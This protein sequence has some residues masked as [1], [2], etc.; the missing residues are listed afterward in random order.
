MTGALSLGVA[1]VAAAAPAASI[2]LCVSTTAGGSVTSGGTTGECAGGSDAVALPSEASAQTKLL[3][4]LPYENFEA[5]GIDGKP[6]IQFSGANVQIISGASG[7]TLFGKENVTNGQGNLIIGYNA[8]PNEQT[9]SNNL[10]MGTLGQKYTSVGAIQ[11]GL[12]N[13]STDPFTVLFGEENTASSY[14]AAVTGG[15]GNIASA[16]ASAVSGGEEG[17][18]SG[19]GS[20]ISAGMQNK[21]TS[22]F[23]SVSGGR[24][25]VARFEGTISGGRENEAV[26]N[27]NVSGGEHNVA[28][29]AHSNV[30]GGQHNTA[31]GPFASILGGINVTEPVENGHNP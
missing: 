10:V 31:S 14:G 9:G 1:T 27:G 6:T 7:S 22:N 29:G 13:R 19:F 3:S 17:E 16:E 5:S 8:T 25:N 30:S 24:G 12:E 26:E 18:A 23:A 2:Y 21:A 28:S 15:A 20:S 4:I 11:G